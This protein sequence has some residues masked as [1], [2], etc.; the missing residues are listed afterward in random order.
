MDKKWDVLKVFSGTKA[1]ERQTMG[2]EISL[3]ISI[4]KDKL[5][6]IDAQVL[7]SSDS[8]YHCL[9]FVLFCKLR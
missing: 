6:I 1:H 5:D 4:V 9:T 2:E 8:S 7:Q 3:W